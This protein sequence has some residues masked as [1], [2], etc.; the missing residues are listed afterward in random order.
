MTLM[1]WIVLGIIKKDADAERIAAEI[2]DRWHE[3]RIPGELTEVLGLS[4]REYQ[5]W[6][7]GNVSL[8]TI[9]TWRTRPPALDP[10]KPWFRLSGRPGREVVGYLDQVKSRK[11]TVRSA[12]SSA[13]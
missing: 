9:A 8:L 12:G 1:D 5:A 2:V 6:T 3:D 4:H 10:K 13:S 11:K 7:T